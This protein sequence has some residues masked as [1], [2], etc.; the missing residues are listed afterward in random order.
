MKTSTVLLLL[1]FL[2]Q[3]ANIAVWLGCQSRVGE[4]TVEWKDGF[5]SSAVTTWVCFLVV[6]A[7]VV[8]TDHKRT[9]E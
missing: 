8:F 3:A 5:N 2:L 4:L 9:D 1:A 7:V 6:L